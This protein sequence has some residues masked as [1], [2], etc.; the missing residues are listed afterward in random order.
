MNATV[1]AIIAENTV[2]LAGIGAGW[3]LLRQGGGLRLQA[4]PAPRKTPQ[5]PVAEPA[6]QTKTAPVVTFNE[7]K[8]A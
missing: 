4:P 6:G 8:P 2:I 3:H 5:Q 7:R 1:A